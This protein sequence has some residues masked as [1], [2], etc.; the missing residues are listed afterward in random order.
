MCNNMFYDNML[1]SQYVAQNNYNNMRAQIQQY[2][3][4]QSQEV[5]N[6]VKATHDLCEVVKMLDMEHQQQAAALFLAKFAR[7]INW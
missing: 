2:Q 4:N 7:K 5:A 1:N 6:A 3:I